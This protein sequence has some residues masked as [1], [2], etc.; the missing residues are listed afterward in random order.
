MESN[1][2]PQSGQQLTDINIEEFDSFFKNSSNSLLHADIS[3][4]AAAAEELCEVIRDELRWDLLAPDIREKFLSEYVYRENGIW[5][6]LVQLLRDTMYEA[7]QAYLD[8]ENGREICQNCPRCK[9]HKELEGQLS[10]FFKLQTKNKT[11]DLSSNSK[12]TSLI[13]DLSPRLELSPRAVVK[14]KKMRYHS[15]LG[16]TMPCLQLSPCLDTADTAA[17]NPLAS[18]KQKTHSWNSLFFNHCPPTT[19]ISFP[20]IFVGGNNDNLSQMVGDVC[21][22]HDDKRTLAPM[23]DDDCIQNV[24]SEEI[25]NFQS[26]KVGAKWWQSRMQRVRQTNSWSVVLAT[27]STVCDIFGYWEGRPADPSVMKTI[28]RLMRADAFNHEEYEL[29]LADCCWVLAHEVQRPSSVP[30]SSHLAWAAGWPRK[31]PGAQTYQVSPDDKMW[32]NRLLKMAHGR[33]AYAMSPLLCTVLEAAPANVKDYFITHG[34]MVSELPFASLHITGDEQVDASSPKVHKPKGYAW[35][36]HD[37][38]LLKEVVVICNNDDQC[39]IC[40]ELLTQHSELYSKGQPVRL[41]C[42]CRKFRFHELCLRNHLLNS[43]SCPMCRGVPQTLDKEEKKILGQA[44]S[45]K[46]QESLLLSY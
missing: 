18:R 11:V 32:L 26:S 23:R 46:M 7:S 34:G 5:D 39:A 20:Q 41:D 40:L 35:F 42:D 25:S 22:R 2:E 45:P 37:Q 1:E 12:K 30:T 33:G 27:L 43:K 6:K 24:D 13:R 4:S 28:I 44:P 38:Y 36:E 9:C 16:G 3:T 31:N 21:E 17:G 29:E 8:S 10:F 19:F 14:G 15:P